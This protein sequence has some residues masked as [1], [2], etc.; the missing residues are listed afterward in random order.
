MNLLAYPHYYSET[1]ASDSILS[2]RNIRL[3]P[4]PG[5]RPPGEYTEGLFVPS[6]HSMNLLESHFPPGLFGD[7]VGRIHSRLPLILCLLAPANQ[8]FLLV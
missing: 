5:I 7:A 8:S 2:L 3:A 1:F 6:D 4:T